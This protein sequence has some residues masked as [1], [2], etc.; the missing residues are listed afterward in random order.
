MRE[1]ELDNMLNRQR[2]VRVSKSNPHQIVELTKN[3]AV[4]NTSSMEKKVKEKLLCLPCLVVKLDS[5]VQQLSSEQADV[6]L[7]NQQLRSVNTQLQHQ[8]EG[9]R[10]QL[11][12]TLAQLRV[13]EHNAAQEQDTRQ[14]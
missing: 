3:R 10:E 6:R 14:R 13:L 5:R 1:Q 9:G 8:L 11:Q 7:Q 12:A 2:E 4:R